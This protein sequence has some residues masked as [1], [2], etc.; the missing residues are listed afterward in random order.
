M[1]SRRLCEFGWHGDEASRI[2]GSQLHTPQFNPELGLLYMWSAA[3]SPS[4]RV[5]LFQILLFPNTVPPKNIRGGK[6]TVT[7]ET[8]L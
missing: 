8:L 2:A 7:H 6:L 4:V 5:A 1:Y 3:R